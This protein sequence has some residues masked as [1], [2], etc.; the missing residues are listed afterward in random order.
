[1]Y[2]TFFITASKCL[3][4]GH[5]AYVAACVTML[6]SGAGS[7]LAVSTPSARRNPQA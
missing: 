5:L 7:P 1:M 3:P 6:G 4:H 2:R